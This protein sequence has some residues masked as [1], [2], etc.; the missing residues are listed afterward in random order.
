MK[1]KPI[2]IKD[3]K[4]GMLWQPFSWMPF[5]QVT[6]IRESGFDKDCVLINKQFFMNKNQY[7][8]IKEEE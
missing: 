4:V 2:K 3:L 7:T 1:H 5:Q 8:Y 6:S